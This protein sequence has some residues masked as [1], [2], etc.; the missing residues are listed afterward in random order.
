MKPAASTRIIMFL[1]RCIPLGLRRYLFT[2]FFLLFYY[3]SPRQRLIALHNLC[4]AYPDKDIRELTGIAKGVFRH[5]GIVA[6]E[7]FE[8]PTITKENLHEWV[9]FEG[10]ENLQNALAQGKGVLSVVA[11]FGNWELMTVAVPLAAQ[12]MGIIYRPLDSPVL[13]DMLAWMRT[14]HGN[15]LIPKEGSTKKIVRLLRENQAIGILSDQNVAAREGVF[16]EFF[17]RPACTA[18][19]TAVLAMRTGAPVLPAF[20]P[21]IAN[22][23]YRFVI[24]PP[25]DISVTGDDDADI[26]VNTQRFT[27][28][29]EEMVRQYPDQWFW[30]HQRWKTQPCQKE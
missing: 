5:V 1:F 19:G 21:R 17:G 16:V 6:A 20:M 14:L 8:L 3:L 7:F 22:G 2:S 27:R 28:V 4:R 10:L 25:V 26:L 18:V 11:H 13:D 12:P 23:K 9:E 15:T 29:V 30:I 24:K